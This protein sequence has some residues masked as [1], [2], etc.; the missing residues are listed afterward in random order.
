MRRLGMRR[1]GVPDGS[2]VRGWWRIERS[3]LR[4]ESRDPELRVR[5]PE[6]PEGAS[7]WEMRAPPIPSMMRRGTSR[8]PE[9]PDG[10][11]EAPGSSWPP[12]ARP[13][14]LSGD[15][16]GFGVTSVDG[17]SP[18]RSPLSLLPRLRSMLP[19]SGV[20]VRGVSAARRLR[21]IAAAETAVDRAPAAPFVRRAI[22]S[23][24]L[25]GRSVAA[26]K[27][28]RWILS[29]CRTAIAPDERRLAAAR[30]RAVAAA[31]HAAFERAARAGRRHTGRSTGAHRMM[32]RP[33]PLPPRAARA[34]RARGSHW[35]A[36]G[37]GGKTESYPSRTRNLLCR[38]HYRYRGGRC[39]PPP[40]SDL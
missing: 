8:L 19:R 16:A 3:V 32:S 29:V 13:R 9:L 37:R 11:G 25:S 38:Y 14:Q 17:V 40:R 6:S 4:P 31:I 27:T 23:V 36:P 34:L 10:A 2:D 30:D 15:G 24:V 20:V 33:R 18:R 35:K 1:F 5:V 22:R 39:C 12:T 21:R 26:A 28:G 7:P